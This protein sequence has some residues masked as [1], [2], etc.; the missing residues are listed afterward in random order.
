MK[1]K[2]MS[3][4]ELQKD[5]SKLLEKYSDDELIESLLGYNIKYNPIN[6]IDEVK[7][8][9][10]NKIHEKF[11]IKNVCEYKE[12]VKQ[13]KKIMKEIYYGEKVRRIFYKQLKVYK[14]Y[15]KQC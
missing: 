8:L 2:E 15:C 4:E 3:W 9:G 10:D 7:I 14:L 5:F 6:I 1:F 12:N 11:S 13:D